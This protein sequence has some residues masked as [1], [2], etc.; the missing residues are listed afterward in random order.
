MPVAT[1]LLAL[2]PGKVK[3]L[4][5]F[6]Q[7]EKEYEVKIEHHLHIG[8]VINEYHTN[9]DGC[10]YVVSTADNVEEAIEKAQKVKDNI[11]KTIIRE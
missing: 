2:T 3:A 7:L 6:G 4:P 9:L 11:N 10:G 8:D 5:N 1:K